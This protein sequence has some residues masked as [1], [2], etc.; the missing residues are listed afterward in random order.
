MVLGQYRLV[1]RLEQWS[2]GW[3]DAM[4]KVFFS[5]SDGIT[6]FLGGTNVTIATDVIIWTKLSLTMFFNVMVVHDSWFQ[7]VFMVFVLF[8]FTIV[9]DAISLL[10]HQDWCFWPFYAV[11]S[12][13]RETS[14][15]RCD[16][17]G[18][19]FKSIGA[20]WYLVVQGFYA[21]INWKSGD[22][23]GCYQCVTHS[24]TPR[25]QNI[26]LLSLFKV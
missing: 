17:F 20:A 16:V 11:I 9:N 1:L 19:L 10:D 7:W 14:V 8:E 23:V 3:S 2:N 18:G 6:V 21:F 4:A 5:R 15:Q 24:Q 22:L 26:G 12:N 13:G 25:Q